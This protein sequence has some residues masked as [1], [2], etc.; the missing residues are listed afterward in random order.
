M[1]Q[2]IRDQIISIIDNVQDMTIATIREDGYPQATTVSYV[3]EGLI[4]YFGS[5]VDSQKAKNIARN[6]KVSVT[7]NRNYESWGDIE[8]LS[9]GA[10][11]SPITDPQEFKRVGSL[12][13]E[14]FPQISNYVSEDEEEPVLFRLDPTVISVLDYSKGFGHTELVEI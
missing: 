9:M 1:D 12:M 6:N 4:I 5:S 13:F 7:I 3:N 11:A 10:I 8:G 2:T 14:K